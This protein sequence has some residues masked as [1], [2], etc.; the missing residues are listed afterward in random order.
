ARG[1]CWML[2]S[3]SSSAWSCGCRETTRGMSE[4]VNGEKLRG[5]ILGADA[6]AVL[7]GAVRLFVRE[8]LSCGRRITPAAT[9]TQQ[10][11]TAIATAGEVLRRGAV[12]IVALLAVIGST[13]T[14]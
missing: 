4:S 3:S 14:C 9:A 8:F 12:A 6:V 7:A 5:R 2:R 1:S 11:K 13:S 10:A